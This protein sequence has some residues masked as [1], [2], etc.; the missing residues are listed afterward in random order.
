MSKIYL[1]IFSAAELNK[2]LEQQV[3]DK[4]RRMIR[5][6]S[7]FEKVKNQATLVD[8]L[9]LRA[10]AA[11][12]QISELKDQITTLKSEIQQKEHS[13]ERLRIIG[14]KKDEK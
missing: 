7:E 12:R 6:E 10:E 11:E 2:N 4:D 9:R 8:S 5:L 14:E 13:L 3:L 1:F